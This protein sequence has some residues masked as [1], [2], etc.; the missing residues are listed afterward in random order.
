MVAKKESEFL[1]SPV[2]ITSHRLRMPER[3]FGSLPP[4]AF[5]FNLGCHIAGTLS[6]SLAE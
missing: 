4:L 1:L 6:F 5:G 3:I 2:A